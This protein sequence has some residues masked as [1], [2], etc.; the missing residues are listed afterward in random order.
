MTQRPGY[1]IEALNE[2]LRISIL[3][4][5]FREYFAANRGD[6]VG[7]QVTDAV[8]DTVQLRVTF[9]AGHR[10]CCAE[11]GCHFGPHWNRLRQIASKHYMALPRNLKVCFHGVVEAGAKLECCP[12]PSEADEFHD[13]F[14]EAAQSL[15]QF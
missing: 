8:G 14:D 15:D 2:P 6:P 5:V 4:M 7:V 12:I 10:Y 11:P 3:N 1:S 9:L 13:V